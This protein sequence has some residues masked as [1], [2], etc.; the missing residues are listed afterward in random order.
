MKLCDSHT[1]IDQYSSSE[2]PGILQRAMDSKVAR[3]IP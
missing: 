1:H 3:N 2:L